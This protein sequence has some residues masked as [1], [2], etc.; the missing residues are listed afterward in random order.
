MTKE[1]LTE[2]LI[3]YESKKETLSA[4]TFAAEIDAEV[5]EYKK[6]V[7]AKYEAQKNSDMEKLDHYISL[8]QDLISEAEEE[9]EAEIEAAKEA[10]AE[11]V[12]PVG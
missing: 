3:D 6:T 8:L 9:E 2:K 4:N 1:K 11:G 7:V 5:A 10:Y 12:T